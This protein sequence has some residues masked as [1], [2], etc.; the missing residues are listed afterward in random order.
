MAN[1]D[2]IGKGGGHHHGHHEKTA[3]SKTG[4][5]AAPDT[6]DLSNQGEDRP[7]SVT[8]PQGQATKGEQEKATGIGLPNQGSDDP[9]A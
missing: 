1:P 6:A 4:N 3:T 7:S 5:P 2:P 8:I 9:S